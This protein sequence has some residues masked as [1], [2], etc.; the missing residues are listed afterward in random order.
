M[1]V[2]YEL[3][4]QQKGR[5]NLEAQFRGSQR[6]QAIDEAKELEQQSH[7][8]GAKVVREKIDDATGESSEST[9][10]NSDRK[11]TGRLTDEQKSGGGGGGMRD[12]ADMEV[13]MGGG[14]GYADIEVGGDDAPDLA[15]A[16]AKRKTAGVRGGGRRM[17]PQGLVV[18]K[19]FIVVVTSFGFAALVTWIF[20]QTGLIAFA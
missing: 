13:D 7:I 3:Y 16:P 10:Y 1:A 11:K 2:S 9:I 19:L 8:D 20:L 14:G 4:V 15:E 17:T 12:F 18:Y 6:Q 5:W